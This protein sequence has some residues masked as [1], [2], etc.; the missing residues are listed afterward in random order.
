MAEHRGC[1]RGKHKWPAGPTHAKGKI[2]PPYTT[3]DVRYC[4]KCD[5]RKF[6]KSVWM[7]GTIVVIETSDRDIEL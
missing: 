1:R 5:A 6:T 3:V 4:V 7:D 2:Y